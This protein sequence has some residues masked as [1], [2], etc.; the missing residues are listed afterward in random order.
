MNDD[1]SRLSVRPLGHLRKLRQHGVG[2]LLANH[3]LR[4]K[5]QTR[6]ASAPL[7]GVRSEGQVGDEVAVHDIEL[8]AV[9]AGVF[10]LLAV[11]SQLP[12]VGRKDGRNYLNGAWFSVHCVEGGGGG[13]GGGNPT[14]T[15]AR[16]ESGVK[17]GDRCGEERCEEELHANGIAAMCVTGGL[18]QL[19]M[20]SFGRAARGGPSLALQVKMEKNRTHLH[21][22]PGVLGGS[23][24]TAIS[25]S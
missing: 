3:E 10:Q 11:G 16:D 25:Y 7:D 12:E 1:Y 24:I 21:I 4:L 20:Q 15:V 14:R 2:A 17:P 5:R 6:V 22:K 23:D 13:R 9:A 8:D 19:A 18:A